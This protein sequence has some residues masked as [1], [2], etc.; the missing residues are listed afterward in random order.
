[1]AQTPPPPSPPPDP[2]S[3]AGRVADLEKQL[4]EALAHVAR[5]QAELGA[6][7]AADPSQPP[8]G[9]APLYGPAGHEQLTYPATS[10][11]VPGSGNRALVWFLV[12]FAIAMAGM[13]IYMASVT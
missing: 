12:V 6:A 9:Q 4:A 1:M 7:R 11:E 10:G 5:L 8:A 3:A 13:L 2:A